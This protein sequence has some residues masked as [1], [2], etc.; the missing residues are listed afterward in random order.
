MK[1]DVDSPRYVIAYTAVVSAVFTAVVTTLGVAVKPVIARN[2]ALREDRALVKVFAETLG[3]QDVAGMSREQVA[4]IVARRIDG[5]MR[6]ERLGGTGEPIAVYRAYGEDRTLLAV[7]FPFTGTGFWAPITGLMAI[8]CSSDSATGRAGLAE[9]AGVVFLDHS[10]TPGLGG[11]ITED[12][13][14]DRFRG[15]PVP[16][17]DGGPLLYMERQ[18]PK[19]GDPRRKHAVQAITGATQTS[20]A[21]GRFLNAS[22]RAFRAAWDARPPEAVQT[23]RR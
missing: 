20:M 5:T 22:V 10:E 12:D 9:V 21:V 2:E 18:M 16:P 13:F 11:R 8:R 19:E 15:L 7:A 17:A 23:A 14:Q 1:W 4:D 6:L 3:L